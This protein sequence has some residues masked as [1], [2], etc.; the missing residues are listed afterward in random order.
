MLFDILKSVIKSNLN[1]LEQDRAIP[2]VFGFL[3]FGVIT[4]VKFVFAFLTLNSLLILL[5][6]P[7]KELQQ[8]AWPFWKM[9]WVS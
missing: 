8:S 5:I 4:V 7:V 2:C 6:D 1:T 9:K 3:F